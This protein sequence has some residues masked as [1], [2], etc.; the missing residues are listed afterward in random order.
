MVAFELVALDA[1]HSKPWPFAVYCCI[2]STSRLKAWGHCLGALDRN[3][4]IG[5][6]LGWWI[7][8][9]RKIDVW[10][11]GNSHLDSLRVWLA[12]AIAYPEE[13]DASLKRKEHVI[14]KP[15][16]S[17]GDY[18]S[19]LISPSLQWLTFLTLSSI[20]CPRN[21]LISLS[22]MS[23]LAVLTIGQGVL[24]PDVGL[25][26]RIVRA[27]SNAAAEADAF[28]MLRVLNLREQKHITARIFQYLPKFP[29]LALLSLDACAVG[30]NDKEAAL[31]CGWKYKTGRI[32]NEFLLDIGKVDNTWD[33]TVHACFRAA[34]AYSVESLTHEGVEAINSLPILHSSLGNKP[35][36]VGLN[37]SGNYKLQCFERIKGWSPINEF[38]RPVSQVIQ[39]KSIPRKKPAIRASK[40]ESVGDLFLGMG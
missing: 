12:F 23:N 32:L 34:G 30:N 16:M 6:K 22:R 17:L 1:L 2:V 29:S 28:S 7:C 40:Q 33:S 10:L 13:H 31:A 5:Y 3:F 4:G 38:K 21:D 27:W 18:T 20:T 11:I 8:A 39:E 26:D 14:L 9:A 15:S 36:D 37:T 24:T 19:P 25:E 35:P